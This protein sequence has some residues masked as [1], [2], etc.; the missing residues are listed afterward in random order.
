MVRTALT[1]LPKLSE[2]QHEK[3]LMLSLL[4]LARSHATLTY[5]ALTSAL[6]L[7]TPRAL[8][9]LLTTAIYA[10]LLTATLDP[11]HSVVSVTSVAP[12]RDLA[13]GSLPALQATLASWSNR[14]DSALQDLELRVVEV[15]RAAVE[16]E[17]LR[18]KKE[19]ALE[20][21]LAS[22]EDKGKGGK[23]RDEGYEDA[24]DIDEQGGSGRQTRGQK[25]GFAG[26]F[27]GLGKRLG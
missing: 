6:D 20:V 15:R 24:M 3:L 16:R 7:P 26:G 14:C 17:I 8:E 25:R 12:L 19:R 1:D 10:G 5:P 9:Q 4:P 2:K 21:M 22:S 18:R 11:A 13:P 23:A 27:S